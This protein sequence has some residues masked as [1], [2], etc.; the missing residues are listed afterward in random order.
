MNTT[1]KSTV[2]QIIKQ[3]L[4][5]NKIYPGDIVNAVFLKTTSK[6][7][8]FEIEKF[9]TGVLYGIEFL[10]AKNIV[11]KLNP[12]DNIPARVLCLENEDGF[13]ELSLSDADKQNQWKTIK[14]LEES[15]EVV[16]MKIIGANSGGLI[17]EILGLKAFL[18]LSK[19][20][21]LNIS[22]DINNKEK[23]VAELKKFI[24]KEIKVKVVMSNH[25]TNKLVVSEKE[26]L[27]PN[28]SE[29]IAQ[30]KPGQILEGI[31]SGITDFGVFV[32]LIDN[33][34][35]EGVVY[36][37]EIDYRIID[38]AKDILKINDLVKVKI[39]EIKDNKLILSIKATKPDP[40]EN[41]EKYK[42]G[43]E[44]E[45][46]VYKFTPFGALINFDDLQGI[47]HITD[48]GSAEEM[49]NK[50]ELH[51]EYK[52]IIHQIKPEEKRIILKLNQ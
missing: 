49:K 5:K 25:R 28:I 8:F 39:L 38:N 32:Q 19:I 24:G 36:N 15:G 18:P 13:I 34:Q 2:A 12:G 3:E 27:A 30:Y 33:P 41:I 44:I 17:G 9:G 51:K 35:V 14:E 42:V 50:L 11:K 47:I 22:S 6:G 10:N 40:W 29:L 43:Q 1:N 21:S 37:S 48:F 52:F 20:S 16:D 45:G 23:L 26:A 46:K 4:S 31:I 7:A